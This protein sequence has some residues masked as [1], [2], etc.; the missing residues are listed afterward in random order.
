MLPVQVQ[1]HG[2]L[3]LRAEA[4]PVV[5]KL[6]VGALLKVCPCA[7]PHTPLIGDGGLLLVRLKLTAVAPAAL[8][9]T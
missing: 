9:S 3:P 6:L 7:L 8:T 1:L 2:P 4:V 5:Q